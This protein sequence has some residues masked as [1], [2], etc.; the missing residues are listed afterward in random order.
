[1]RAGGSGKSP[2]VLV[3][4]MV[5]WSLLG[6]LI[7]RL[8]YRPLRN[9]PRLSVLIAAIGVS[10]LLEYSAQ[11]L[12][13]ADPKFFPELLP[14]RALIQFHGVVVSNIQVLILAVSFGLMIFLRF[15]V[16][17]TRIGKAIRAVSF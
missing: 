8:V 13:G 15:I 14:N 5:A 16:L 10:L 3:A 6:A 4:S 11:F 2:A 9:A 12:F 1:E 7:E 17:K